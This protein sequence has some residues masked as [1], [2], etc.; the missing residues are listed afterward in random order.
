MVFPDEIIRQ[1][2]NFRRGAVVLLHQQHPGVGVGL[3]EPHQGLRISGPEAVNALILV[4]HHEDVPALLRQKLNDRMLDFRGVLGLVHADIGEHILKMRQHV[5]ALFQNGLSIDHLV[6]VVHPVLLPQR[7]VVPAIQLRELLEP[8]VQVVDLLLVEHAVLGIGDV[9]A[10]L[11]YDALGGKFAAEGA[12]QVGNQLGQKPLVLHQPEGIPAAVGLSVKINDLGG[13]AVD[14][15]KFRDVGAVLAKQAGKALLHLPGG[16]F[17]VGHGQDSVGRDPAAAEHIAQAGHQHGGFSAAGHGQ[18]QDRALCGVYRLCLLP[19][20]PAGI[21]P[22]KC[23]SV[24]AAC[25]SK[26]FCSSGGGRSV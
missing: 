14:G 5:R 15:A 21:F 10:K 8:G 23:F 18:Q 1:A 24:H 16:G 3:P 19:V 7:Q 13:N 22:V 4:A 9:L 2:E 12:V 11:F 20:Q 25:P 26:T 17:C 6:V